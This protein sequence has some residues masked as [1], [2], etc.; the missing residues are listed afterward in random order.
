MKLERDLRNER[1]RCQQEVERM[2][3]R[4]RRSE[5]QFQERLEKELAALRKERETIESER[6]DLLENVAKQ[7]LRM[8]Q[9]RGSIEEMKK[10]LEGKRLKFVEEN[11]GFKAEKTL[12]EDKYSNLHE[13]EDA[14]ERKKQELMDLGRETLEKTQ[15]F[16][17]QSADYQ[18]TK[19]ELEVLRR[20]HHEME[21]AHSRE[22]QEMQQQMDHVS[23]L[24]KTLGAMSHQLKHEK[25]LISKERS[26]SRQVLDSANRLER[27]LTCQANLTETSWR[28][29]NQTEEIMGQQRK[30]RSWLSMNNNPI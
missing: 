18:R 22:K 9:E 11:A 30:L 12:F 21:L 16:A 14:L 26:E 29:T 25:L 7:N 15:H 4:N 24:Q 8:E 5:D 10:S 27:L 17:T 3:G 13:R 19:T 6:I 23:Q 20:T 28:N 1:T 2:E